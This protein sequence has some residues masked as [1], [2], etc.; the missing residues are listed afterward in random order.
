VVTFKRVNPPIDAQAVDEFERY[1]GM[2]LPAD[3]RR[4]LLEHNG[5]VPKPN[6]FRIN[7]EGGE[8]SVHLFLGL[9]SSTSTVSLQT[10]A[11]NRSR[12][13]P[14]SVIPIAIDPGYHLLCMSI[15]KPDY[16]SI[17]FWNADLAATD[18]EIPSYANLFLLS[19]SFNEFLSTL[20]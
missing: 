19:D 12:D 20:Y 8:D 10:F 18:S 2:S 5:G 17:Y 16:G 3:Y 6:K 15:K 9:L 1:L 4:F 11:R 7:L 14:L 13:M